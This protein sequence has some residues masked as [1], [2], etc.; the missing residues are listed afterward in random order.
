[1]MN[2]NRI[3]KQLNEL[4]SDIEEIKSVLTN[5]KQKELSDEQREILLDN[6]SY[7]LTQM[8]HKKFGSC[9]DFNDIEEIADEIGLVKVWGCSYPYSMENCFFLSLRD[10]VIWIEK[11]GEDVRYEQNELTFWIGGHKRQFVQSFVSK[12]VWEKRDNQ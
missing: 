10:L 12:S 11:Y 3:L 8:L 6:V 9:L 7:H 1:M 5:P 2:K 4:I